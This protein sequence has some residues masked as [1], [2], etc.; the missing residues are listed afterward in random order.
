MQVISIM[1]ELPVGGQ[2]YLAVTRGPPEAERLIH[3][4]CKDYECIP[5][6][7]DESTYETKH[8][9]GERCCEPGPVPTDV[10]DIIK[11]NGTPNVSWIQATKDRKCGLTVTEHN[12][13]ENRTPKY[14]AISHV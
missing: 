6:P 3:S 1:E 13:N 11:R 2:Y 5:K 14:I 12:I 10:L 9:T 8:F 7:I 4:N